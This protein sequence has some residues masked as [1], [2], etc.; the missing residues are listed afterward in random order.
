[1]GMHLY[2]SVVFGFECSQRDFKDTGISQW[3]Y[4]NDPRIEFLWYEGGPI[5]IYANGSY[6]QIAATGGGDID[7]RGM[8]PLDDLKTGK[9]S[10]ADM[11][12]AIKNFCT[13]TGFPYRDPQWSLVWGWR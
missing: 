4:E 1:M 7:P 12:Q 6:Q 3:D 8:V 2:V 13:E 11:T 10:E 9:R 5:L